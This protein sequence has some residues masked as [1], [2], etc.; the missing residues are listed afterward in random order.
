MRLPRDLAVTLIPFMGIVATLSGAEADEFPRYSALQYSEANGISQ[1][2]IMIG[3]FDNNDYLTYAAV[4]FGDLGEGNT[5]RISYAKDNNHGKMEARL[6][7]PQGT[8]IGEFFPWRTG[9]W[10]NFIETYLEISEVEGVHDLTFVAKDQWGVLN[11][12][13]FELTSEG[14]NTE[15][16][17]LIGKKMKKIHSRSSNERKTKTHFFLNRREFPRSTELA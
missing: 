10:E 6:G 7:G 16:E 9:S 3:S 4:D 1:N 11:L 13:W 5:M 14:N 8:K 2:D 15:W 17:A 12:K